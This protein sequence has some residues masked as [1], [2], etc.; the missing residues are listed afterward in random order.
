MQLPDHQ[1]VTR[2]IMTTIIA[3]VLLL[4]TGCAPDLLSRDIRDLEQMPQTPISYLD[5]LTAHQPLL[6]AD[7]QQKQAIDLLERHF[8][9]WHTDLPLE[10]TNSPFWAIDWI[11]KKM[12]FGENLRPV[13]QARIQT[14]INLTS[15][16]TYP[17]LNRRAITVRRSDLR[18]LP[19]PKPLFNNPA[20]A[21][22]GFPF[23]NLQH[24]SVP[25]NTPLHVS[26]ISEDGAWVFAETTW[27]Y[28]WLPVND[29]AWIDEE[30]A[31]G[32]E[33]GHYL[34]PIQ[35]QVPVY[36]AGGLFRFNS[37]M[38]A[39]FPLI[40][41]G[42]AR[43]EVLIAIAD[44][45]RQALLTKAVVPLDSGEVFPLPLT[46]GQ[47][48]SLA[49]HMVG[50]AYSWGGSLADRDCSSTIRDLFVPFGLWLP[51][52]S[53]KQAKQG[54][55]IPL[56]ELSPNQREK[57]LIDEGIPFLTL[58]RIPGHIMLY[59]G[60]HEDR[61]AVLHTIWGLRT[62]DLWGND[63][64]WVVGKTVITT[65]EPGMERSTLTLGISNLRQRV[66]SMNILRSPDLP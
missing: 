3:A 60:T 39:L 43:H 10:S 36:D 64:R 7:E 42:P 23:D 2:T 50:Q 48:A 24:S 19:T 16:E 35:D 49:G 4:I 38:G 21:G 30:F 29:L 45:D 32:F 11:E 62:Q 31:R 26:H 17:S 54:T 53:S 1:K 44:E 57:H 37:G 40:N 52:N 34:A 58:V 15:R 51:R 66:E 33:T 25:A 27:V 28:G 56:S 22:A 20:K 41:T 59:I 61:A 9:P 47:L 55:V 18:A 13:G 14:L 12:V 65:L 63:G 8:I 5:T 46:S 6:S